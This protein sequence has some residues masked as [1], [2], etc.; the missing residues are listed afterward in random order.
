M[1]IL[2]LVTIRILLCAGLVAALA[3]PP[4]AAAKTDPKNT[5]RTAVHKT[6]AKKSVKK[7]VKKTVKKVTK[8]TTKKASKAPLKPAAPS[9]ASPAEYVS[10]AKDGVTVRA[11][12]AADADA[13][14]E[15]F[16]KFPLRVKKRQGAWLQVSDFEGDTGWIQESLVTGA[17]S[18]I[19]SK[20]RINLR[21]DPN[22]DT[23]NPVV[24]VV[25]YG[26]VFTPLEK[27]DDWLK[28]RYADG[29]EGWLNKDL[30]WPANP[31]D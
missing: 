21:Q 4:H 18:V 29:T 2:R 13:S 10:A 28:V 27:K 6:T 23:N 9:L 25:R 12:P 17:K 16:D 11:N 22:S 5:D 3:L 19:V 31:L 15:I 26:V 20:K 30:V 14:W 1:K 24:A 8:K 7:T